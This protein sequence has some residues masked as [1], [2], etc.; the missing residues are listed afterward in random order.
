MGL[1]IDQHQQF[2]PGVEKLRNYTD[3]VDKDYN[4]E[5]IRE[6]IDGF[7][8]LFTRHMHEE[9]NTLVD[10]KDYLTVEQMSDILS[11]CERSFHG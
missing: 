5:K 9:L 11:G 7:G 2:L 1:N 4:P 3:N 8:D 6:I 10:L